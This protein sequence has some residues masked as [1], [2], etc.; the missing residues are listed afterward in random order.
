M[1]LEPETVRAVMED[2]VLFRV[3]DPLTARDTSRGDYPRPI[4]GV[5]RPMLRWTTEYVPATE[6]AEAGA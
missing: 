5:M 6:L 4:P 2:L 3:V 1:T